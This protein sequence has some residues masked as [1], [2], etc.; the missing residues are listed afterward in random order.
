MSLSLTIDGDQLCRLLRICKLIGGNRPVSFE[1]LRRSMKAS[2]RT[3]FRDFK[4]L[5]KMGI[6][7]KLDGRGYRISQKPLACRKLIVAHQVKLVNKLL[8]KC[9]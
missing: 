7:Y 4:D 1:K 8:A 6:H 2:R 3:I 9:V 5:A